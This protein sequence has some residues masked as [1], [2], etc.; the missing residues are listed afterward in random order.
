MPGIKL[1][2]E[3]AAVKMIIINSRYLLPFPG[4]YSLNMFQCEIPE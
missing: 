4:E 3:M 1:F 2:Q